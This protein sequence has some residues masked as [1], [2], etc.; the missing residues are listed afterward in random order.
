MTV[1]T[2][3]RAR[4]LVKEML[5]NNEQVYAVY[6]YTHKITHKLLFA[7]FLLSTYCD[8]YESPFCC[9]PKRIWRDGL[10]IGDYEYLNEADIDGE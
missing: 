8:I 6:E 7:V 1:E 4:A 3:Q 2:A 5:A 10:W 9:K